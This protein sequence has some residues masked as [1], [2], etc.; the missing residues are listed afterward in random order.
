MESTTLGPRD[1]G[2]Y[3]HVLRI[4]LPMVLSTSSATIMAFVDRMFLGWYSSDAMAAALVGG[5]TT[6]AAT[7]TF[8]GIS[9][10]TS[11]FVAQYFGAGQKPRIA[12]VVWQGVFFAMAAGA[13]LAVA[14][15]NADHILAL[16]RHPPEVL[17]GEI[18]FFRILMYGGVF[19]V[20]SPA[21]SGFY[22]GLGR[23]RVMM[24]VET[25]GNVLNIVLDYLLIFGNFGL[26][27]LGIKGAAIATVSAGGVICL[28]YTALILFGPLGREYRVLRAPRIEW[29][30]LYRL[31]RFGFPN[32]L[33]WTVDAAG[34]TAFVWLVGR[35]GDLQAQALSATFAIN[36]IAFLPMMGFS[37]ATAILVGQFIGAGRAGLA[38]RATRTAFAITFSYMALAA[39]L[40]VLIP[41][42]LVRLLSPRA[43][44]GE[45]AAVVAMAT[46]LLRLVALY[47]LFD[48][49]NIIFAA[50]LRGAGDTKFVLFM[51]A[52]LSLALL[53]APTYLAVQVFRFGIYHAMVI[54][55]IY[56]I[57]LA[58][59]YYVRF[60]AGR[61]K[62]MKV[63]EERAGGAD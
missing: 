37:G 19:G 12:V 42:P 60:R 45:F 20:L 9:S 26:P 41:G 46:V 31:L 7:S 1:D 13:C 51:M 57:V 30:L 16:T 59:S 8:V 47:S 6:W 56:V 29:G 25:S 18:T 14:G 53:I 38:E 44:P 15:Q 58:M 2:G 43:N 50:A 52:A 62:S 55:T 33:G 49:G 10:Y 35:L 22:G 54:A 36:Q 21:L 28:S 4:A 61:W 48:G 3:R 27:E 17:S 34:W 5:M 40:F 11:T 32:G 63:I 24:V 23:T 39:A